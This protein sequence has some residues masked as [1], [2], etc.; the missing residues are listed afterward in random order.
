MK[1]EL[2]RSEN[3]ILFGVC[4]G[5]A[6]Y[7]DLDVTLLRLAFVFLLIFPGFFPFGLF[8]IIAAFVIPERQKIVYRER[9]ETEATV[10]EKETE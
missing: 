3:R 4:G 5:L 9:E 2:F 1:K 6:A 7:F 8:Y 10:T